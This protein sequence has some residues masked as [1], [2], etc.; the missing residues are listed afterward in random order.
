MIDYFSDDWRKTNPTLGG[1]KNNTSSLLN[2]TFW[3]IAKS[4]L[5]IRDEIIIMKNGNLYNSKSPIDLVFTA[6]DYERMIIN[7]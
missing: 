5:Q 1:A 7:D 2:P 6:D 3:G 4:I